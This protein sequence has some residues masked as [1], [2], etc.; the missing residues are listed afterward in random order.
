MLF[1][2]AIRERMAGSQGGGSI[3]L[4]R[5]TLAGPRRQI[6][7]E[8]GDEAPA[9]GHHEHGGRPLIMPA[10]EADAELAR[11][12]VGR[13][14]EWDSS[15]PDPFRD[16]KEASPGEI[17][18]KIA[19]STR[20]RARARS[21]TGRPRSRASKA[22]ERMKRPSGKI[23][24][25]RAAL[26]SRHLD[27]VDAEAMASES[28]SSGAPRQSTPSRAERAGGT[29]KSVNVGASKQKASGLPERLTV[30]VTPVT[31]QPF[32]AE[33]D[34]VA[35]ITP[36]RRVG[37]VKFSLACLTDLWIGQRQASWKDVCTGDPNAIKPTD[38]G[39]AELARFDIDADG[40]SQERPPQKPVCGFPELT[41]PT[42]LSVLAAGAYSGRKISFQID[43]SGHEGT[44]IDVAV[45]SPDRPV[46]LMLGAYEP[47]V[48]NIGWSKETRILAVWSGAITGRQSP[49]WT[50]ASR[51]W[52]APTTTKAPA[53]TS[54]SAPTISRR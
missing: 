2:A 36:D 50:R 48:W 14:I 49:A 10:L 46:V 18:K 4:P 37:S 20:A 39:G 3:P 22:R 34:A 33:I 29:V 41:F 19:R 21:D 44:Q 40:K 15:T 47:T 23:K 13:V 1:H 7:F 5:R 30:S 25:A 11:R 54:T 32:Y 24:R 38:R 26:R 52:S 28:R 17:A 53:G 31:G 12:R 42:N 45:N 35:V 27:P 8:T 43:Q 16:R 9:S 6:L 51:Y